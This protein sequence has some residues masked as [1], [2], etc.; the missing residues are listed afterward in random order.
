VGPISGPSWAPYAK[1]SDFLVSLV[2]NA[3]LNER[4]AS[5]RNSSFL[6]QRA[7]TTDETSEATILQG[8]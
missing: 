6:R 5:I 2:L 1:L 8:F 7:A 4:V 3:L